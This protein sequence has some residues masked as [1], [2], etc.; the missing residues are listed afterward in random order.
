MRINGPDT[1]T[2]GTRRAARSREAEAGEAQAQ[3][4]RIILEHLPLVRA[5]AVRVHENL[6]V[7]VELDDLAG[8]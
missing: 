7:H 8:C 5:I 4:D 2:N 1:P 6:P 3:R